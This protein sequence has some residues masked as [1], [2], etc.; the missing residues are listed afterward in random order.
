ML[1]VVG[2][3]IIIL[4]TG[5]LTGAVILGSRPMKV[6]RAP[7]RER[8]ADEA[9]IRAYDRVSRWP[10]FSME[11]HI[12]LKALGR[13]RPEGWLMDLGCGPGYLAARIAGWFPSLNLAGLDVSELTVDIAKRHWAS[14][15]HQ[16]LEF[17][18]GD[19]H[20]L[21]VSGNSVDFVTSSL[22]LH[23][24]PDPAQ[25]FAE[26]HRILRPGGR[27]LVFDL[28]RDAPGLFYFALKA[29]QALLA[30]RAIRRANGAVGS[31]WAAYTP[32]EVGTLL[33]ELPWEH[34]RIERG[35]GWMLIW[36]RKPEGV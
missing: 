30:P 22:S 1:I 3:F 17:L 24:W 5:T 29:G 32:S 15:A 11:R 16:H 27:F 7:D 2:A 18:V 4:L 23:H 25:A 12:V 13:A 28:R 31:F 26:I 35:L 9:A 21:P 8:A 6:P 20:H 19:V 14:G 34:L 36:G 33:G 10:I